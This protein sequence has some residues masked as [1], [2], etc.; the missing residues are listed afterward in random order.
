MVNEARFGHPK[1]G[2]DKIAPIAGVPSLTA[3]AHDPASTGQ[4]R[5]WGNYMLNRASGGGGLAAEPARLTIERHSTAAAIEREWRHLEATGSGTLFQRFDWLEPWLL[6]VAPHVALE[7]ALLVGRLDGVPAFILPLGV[8][9]AG[10]TRV[11]EPLGGTHSGYNFGLWSLAG[12]AQVAALPRS[13]LIR[14]LGE[15]VGADGMILRRVPGEMNGMTQPL[16]ALGSADSAVSGYATSLEGGIEALLARTGG[17]ARRR[18]ANQKERRLREMGA[19]DIGA[20]ADMAGVN[21]ALDFYA[22]QKALRLAEQGLENPFAEPGTMEF[23]R[24]LA[25]RSLGS[26][27]PVLELI[28]LA[29]DGRIRAVLG[30]GVHGGCVSLQILTFIHDETYPHS[31]GQLLLYRH[32]EKSCTDGRAV[33]D[34]GIG[35]EGYKDSWSDTIHRLSDHYAAFGHTGAVAMAALR[36]RDGAKSMLRNNPL[37]VRMVGRWRGRDGKEHAA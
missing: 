1:A 15:A 8:R 12:A 25:R 28:T 16:S 19:I 3:A 21:A 5:A 14:R 24:E 37:A 36:A 10:L 2:F 13:E 34:F 18:R 22:E 7:P 6:N 30:A 4:Q 33:Y 31:P 35:Q 9:R 32:I 26:P 11:A 20:A 29:L 23:L 17:G 27:E